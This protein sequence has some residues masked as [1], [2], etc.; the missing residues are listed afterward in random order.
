MTIEDKERHTKMTSILLYK[1]YLGIFG[2]GGDAS[3][4]ENRN[5]IAEIFFV[6]ERT[7]KC[8]LSEQKTT[9]KIRI[10]NMR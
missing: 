1:V 3:E 10:G 2:I 9:T 8:M 5:Q 4:K 7:I 6:A